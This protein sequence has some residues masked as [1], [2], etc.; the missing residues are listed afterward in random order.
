[1]PIMFNTLLLE[2][3][4]PLSSVRLLRYKDRRA[5]KASEAQCVLLGV[6]CRHTQR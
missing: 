2:A 1:M 3:G 6:L 5:A 4:I